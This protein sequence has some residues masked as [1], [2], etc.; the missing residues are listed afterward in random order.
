MAEL[1]LSGRTKPIEL[2]D[3]QRKAWGE[4]WHENHHEEEERAFQAIRE[5]REEVLHH[6]GNIKVRGQFTVTNLRKA[7]KEFKARTA[8]GLDHTTFKEIEQAEDEALLHLCEIMKNVCDSMT[9]PRQT[10]INQ[11]SLLGKKSGGS[12]CIAICTTFYRLFMAIIKPD[13]REW[14]GR[15]G[16]RGDS[17]VAGRSP[18]IET[19]FR[20][21]IMEHST[22]CG[23]HVV[24][25]LWDIEKYFDSFDAQAAIVRSP[26][27]KPWRW[28]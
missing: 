22:L 12:R 19:T 24:Q 16:Q 27:R 5:L 21:A 2:V 17:A 9:W 14:D 28:V 23:K 4:I 25:L 18:L 11:I 10:L 1:K 3:A 15:V 8:I 20:H 13:V 7:L 6:D 26:L